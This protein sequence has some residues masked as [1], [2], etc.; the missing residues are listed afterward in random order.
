VL[1]ILA[2]LLLQSTATI[3]R[4][5][6]VVGNEPIFLS[7]V[8][9]VVRLRLVDAGDEAQALERM[10]ERRLVLAEVARYSQAPPPAAALDAAVAAWA[11]KFTEA[12][13]HDAAFVRAFLADTLRIEAY[14]QLRFQALS[15]G[16][17][18]M[19]DWLKGLR[20]RAQVRILR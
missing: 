6:A 20:D 14:V 10:I 15:T 9:E 12:P 19:R 3:D 5:V 4:L 13:A 17:T 2:A 16:E 11:A 1:L 8:R 18:A 7:D